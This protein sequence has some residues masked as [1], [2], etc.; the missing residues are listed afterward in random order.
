[1]F[2][3]DVETFFKNCVCYTKFEFLELT[4]ERAS[5]G[6]VNV[7]YSLTILA[8]SASPLGFQSDLN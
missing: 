7:S 5:A 6:L 8:P 3:C 4:K 2:Y 1:M